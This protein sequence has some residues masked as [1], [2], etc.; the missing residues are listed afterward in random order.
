MPA[1]FD[2]KP[3]DRLVILAIA[4]RAV[5]LAAKYEA[6][7]PQLELIMDITA[8]HANGCELALSQLLISNDG[9]FAHDVFGISRHID[10]KTGHL[11]QCF[12]PRYA[13][14]NHAN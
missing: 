7:Y 5:K 14:A 10:R 2:V 8:C 4:Q 11:G 9:D 6:L 13:R 3:E 12:M 1:S